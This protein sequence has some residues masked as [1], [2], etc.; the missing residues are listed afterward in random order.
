MVIM[1][2][3]LVELL[4]Q[5]VMRQIPALEHLLPGARGCLWPCL[6]MPGIKCHRF[7]S[8]HRQ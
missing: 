5:M 4:Y 8:P 6:V 3:P 2:V 7:L 1:R